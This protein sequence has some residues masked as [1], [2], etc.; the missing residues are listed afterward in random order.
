MCG[1]LLT[2]LNPSNPATAQASSNIIRCASSGS[3]L[4][5]LQVM[6][7]H[8]GPGWTFTLFSGLCLLTG[9]LIYLE[10]QYGLKWRS[11]KQEL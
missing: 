5:A 8:M 9:P 2:D 6:I 3:G 4:A 1:T 11:K 10:V 7:S